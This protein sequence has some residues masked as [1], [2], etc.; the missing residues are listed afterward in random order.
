[1]KES[2][3]GA[4]KYR[5]RSAHAI[6]LLKRSKKSQSEIARIVGIT[7]QTVNYLKRKNN[8]RQE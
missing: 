5:S 4:I 6:A 2:K 1:M 7:P 3:Q 8:L